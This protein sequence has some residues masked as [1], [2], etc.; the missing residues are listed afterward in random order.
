MNCSAPILLITSYVD[1]CYSGIYFFSG[2]GNNVIQLDVFINFS[3]SGICK[4]RYCF[5][6]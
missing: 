2:Q 3:Y 6:K 1:Q 4:T 5:H